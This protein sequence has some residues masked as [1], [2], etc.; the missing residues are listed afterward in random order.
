[1]TESGR[2][3]VNLF[4]SEGWFRFGK[5]DPNG[6]LSGVAV[7]HGGGEKNILALSDVVDVKD[8]YLV[9]EYSFQ[10]G[11]GDGSASEGTVKVWIPWEKIEFVFRTN[12]KA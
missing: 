12:P 4:E 2:N 10:S 8:E 9:F 3:W 5:P 7:Y 1:M 6:S 11:T